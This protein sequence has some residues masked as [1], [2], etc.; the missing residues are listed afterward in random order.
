MKLTNALLLSLV[1]FAL[2]P[3]PVLRA[4]D[5]GQPNILLIVADDLGWGDVGWHGSKFKTPNM[6]RLVREGVELDRHYVQP[7]CSPTRTAL[8]S[9]R[10]TS[11]SGPHALSPTNR[12]V[13]PAGTTTLASALKASGYATHLA[14]KW[15]LGSRPEWGPM[16]RKS[17][18]T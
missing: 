7:V 8:L 4:A 5:S 16:S 2:Q 14:G 11:R 1:F 15:H 3:A 6:D 13:F 9:G 17:R 18:R 10:W 12:R